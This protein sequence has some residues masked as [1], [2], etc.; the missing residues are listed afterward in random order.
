MSSAILR[1]RGLSVSYAG[2]GERVRAV[3]DVCFDVRRGETIGVVGESGCGKSTMLRALLGLVRAPGRVDG[4]EVH[5][6]TCGDLL[7]MSR[8]RLRGV[9]GREIALVFQ[10]PLA[11]LDPLFSIGDQLI[12]ALR[13]GGRSTKKAQARLEAVRLLERVHLP[14]P[15]RRLGHYPHQLSGGMCQRVA[16][17]LALAGSPALLLADEPTSALD[18]TIQDQILSLLAELQEDLGMAILLVS[19][20]PDVIAQCSDRVL[21]MH[22]GRMLEP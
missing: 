20:D 3:Q 9:R 11:S 22:A 18:V 14:A 4:G 7:G 13:A 16:I 21:R 19:H 8:A 17:A 5:W 6:H 15:A 2:A 1:V 12:E 10:D